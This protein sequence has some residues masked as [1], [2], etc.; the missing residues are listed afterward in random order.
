MVRTSLATGEENVVLDL[1][2]R[3]LHSI[4]AY[5]E[6]AREYQEALRRSRPV[7]DV[8]RFAGIAG[9]GALVLDVGCGPASDMRHLADAGLEPVGVDLSMGALREARLLRPKNLIVR[10]PYASLPFRHRAFGGLWLSAALVHLPRAEWRDTFALLLS[11]LEAGPVYFSCV[12][13]TADL[14]EVDDPVLGT[15]YRSDATE[16][17]VATLMASHGLVDLQVEV[18]PDPVLDRA[19]PWVVAMGRSR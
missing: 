17:E 7:A 13:G 6:H 19:R 9:R 2:K 4:E 18:R 1:D 8:K 15:L 12:R 16:E 5:D 11:Y 14:E 3:T 10:A